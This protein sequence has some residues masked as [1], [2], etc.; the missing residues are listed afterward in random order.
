MCTHR[1]EAKEKA[2]RG[3]KRAWSSQQR[4]PRLRGHRTHPLLAPR[5][6]KPARAATWLMLTRVHPWAALPPSCFTRL[7]SGLSLSMSWQHSNL[8][9]PDGHE[10]GKPRVERLHHNHQVPHLPPDAGWKDHHLIA[11]VPLNPPAP[12]RP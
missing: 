6:S 4:W 2:G 12:V 10:L 1:K 7:A 5:S 8:G 9:P 11:E 3:G